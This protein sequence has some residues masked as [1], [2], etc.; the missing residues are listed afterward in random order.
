MSKTSVLVRYLEGISD[1]QS[2]DTSA[3]T[4]NFKFL[5]VALATSFR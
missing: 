4:M 3:E 1:G 5:I 2:E